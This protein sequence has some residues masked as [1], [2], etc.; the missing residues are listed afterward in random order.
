MASVL[1]P[2]MK[3]STCQKKKSQQNWIQQKTI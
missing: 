1:D 2:N 3:K